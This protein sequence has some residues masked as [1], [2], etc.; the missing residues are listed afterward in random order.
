[1]FDSSWRERPFEFAACL[2]HMKQPCCFCSDEDEFYNRAGAQKKKAARG[3]VPAEVVAVVETAETLLEKRDVLTGER[4]VLQ[5]EIVQEEL[6]KAGLP[7]GGARDEDDA[8]DAFMSDVST[9]IGEAR[10]QPPCVAGRAFLW[11]AIRMIRAS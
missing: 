6:R 10:V 9:Q 8:L 7:G 4:E 11:R 5:A 1:M 3:P 2:Q